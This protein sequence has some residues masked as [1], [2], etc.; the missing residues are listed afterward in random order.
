MIKIINVRIVIK[1]QKGNLAQYY[2]LGEKFFRI[3]CIIFSL[4]YFF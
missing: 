1:K 2:L 4:A 3:Q